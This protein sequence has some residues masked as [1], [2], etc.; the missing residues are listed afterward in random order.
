[1]IDFFFGKPRTGKTYRAV[2]YLHDGYLRDLDK[3]FVPKFKNI[4][5]NIGG[6]N[7]ELVNKMF[8]DH[9]SSSRAY[10]LVWSEFYKRL[11][12]LYDMA[13]AEKSDIELNK[14]ADYHNINDCM[15]FIDE[16]SLFLKK[17]D[18]VLSWY[19]A[20]HG[21]F[22]VRLVIIAQ[23]P[24]QIYSE[25]MEHTEIYYE[26]Q[27]QS[28]QLSNSSL[29]YIH[30]SAI[31]FN[32]DNKFSSSSI[33]T[34]PKIYELYKSGEIDKPKKI[35]YK[36]IA[37]ALAALAF[38]IGLFYYFTNTLEKRTHPDGYKE[39]SP[40]DEIVNP[41]D[42]NVTVKKSPVTSSMLLRVRCDNTSCSRI[43]SA[44]QTNYIPKLYFEEALKMIDSKLLA[45]S[46]VRVFDVEYNDRLFSIP[47]DSI[48][49]FSMWNVP[50]VQ[51]SG[52]KQMFGS[53]SDVINSAGGTQ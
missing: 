4:L 43:D 25:Y 52:Q 26:A 28:K 15:I 22:R 8:L 48:K 7:F 50:L 2:R 11:K 53:P 27:P 10:K 18:D 29:R 51:K 1:M 20:Y 31:P 37:I 39:V 6:F 30:Y 14:Y 19:F 35:V 47:S 36:F 33:K 17:Y 40:H 45:G 49:Y 9:G 12:V 44:Y 5:T 42:G 21:H 34:D 32:K 3:D 24:K 38:V 41:Y 23:S 46:T 13:I 16:A